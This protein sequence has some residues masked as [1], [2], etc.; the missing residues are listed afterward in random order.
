MK[1]IDLIGVLGDFRPDM[2]VL[3]A[4]DGDYYPLALPDLSDINYAVVEDGQLV[5]HGEGDAQ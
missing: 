4:D 1:V 2:D 3:V 5:F